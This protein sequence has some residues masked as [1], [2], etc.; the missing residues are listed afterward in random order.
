MATANLSCGQAR[1][2]RPKDAKVDQ[3]RP[4]NFSQKIGMLLG[5]AVT[6]GARDA[7]HAFS[8]RKTSDL[9][10]RRIVA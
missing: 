2:E 10:L 9:G 6:P 1:D 7:E 3:R 5:F 8:V 4:P